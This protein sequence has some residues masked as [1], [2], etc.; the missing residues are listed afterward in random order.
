MQLA[1]ELAPGIRA[2]ALAPAIG[3]ARFAVPLYEGKEASVSG[4]YP[5]GPIGDLED[6]VVAVAYLVSYDAASVHLLAAGYVQ[7]LPGDKTGC[8]RGKIDGGGGYVIWP[9]E[10][11]H[12]DAPLEPSAVVIFCATGRPSE[13]LVDTTLDLQ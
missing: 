3:R 7:R 13:H 12:G 10:P 9:P 8:R 11:S 2:N 4:R 6:V 5:L 1:Q